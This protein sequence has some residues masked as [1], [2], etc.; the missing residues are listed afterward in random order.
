MSDRVIMRTASTFRDGLLCDFCGTVA[1][2]PMI[3]RIGG[4]AWFG[5]LN[6]LSLIAERNV[7]VDDDESRAL[8]AIVDSKD[9]EP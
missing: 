3:L 1:K 9:Y 5:H 4:S 8:A 7:G 2:K 6:C